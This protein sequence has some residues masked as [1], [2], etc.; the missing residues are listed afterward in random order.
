NILK[1]LTHYF[2]DIQQKVAFV[3]TSSPLSYR[4]YIGSTDGGMYG[5]EKEAHQPLKTLISPKTKIENLFLTGQNLRLH[6]ILGVTITGFLTAGEMLGKEAFFK[7][8]FKKQRYDERLVFRFV[9]DLMQ[10]LFGNKR[11]KE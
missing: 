3:Y 2:P 9:S 11:S 5:I 1:K 8:V 10:Q 4:E 7:D 6:G